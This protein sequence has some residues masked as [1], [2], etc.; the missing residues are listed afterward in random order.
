MEVE[1]LLRSCLIS[2]K[3]GVGLRVVSNDYTNTCGEEIPYREFGKFF[4]L[5]LPNL[6][7]NYDESYARDESYR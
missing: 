7:V 6:N 3:E 4:F 2:A 1:S 5:I